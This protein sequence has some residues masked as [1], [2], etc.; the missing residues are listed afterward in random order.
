MSYNVDSTEILSG[1]L[2][3]RVADLDKWRLRQ[4][5]LPEVSFIECFDECLSYIQGMEW[6]KINKFWWYGEGSGN[7]YHETLPAIIADL[8]GEAEIVFTWEG[9]DFVSGL[10]I[11]DRKATEHNKVGY[12][13]VDEGKPF[14]GIEA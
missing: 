4:N 3:I 1:E 2:F 12:T 6:Y 8:R 14:G 13:F 9:G 11:K 5:G 7:A 10:R